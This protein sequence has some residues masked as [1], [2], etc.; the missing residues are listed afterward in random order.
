V[1]CLNNLQALEGCGVG[2]IAVTQGFD[3]DHRN[4]AAKFLLQVLRAAA[5]F[6]RTL[7]VERSRAGQARYRRDYEAGRVGKTVHSRSGKNLPPHRPKKVFDRDQVLR[8]RRQGRSLRAI[9]K[10]MGVGVGTVTW[11]EPLG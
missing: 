6:E 5:E 10:E 7:I 1:D 11:T 3:T 9:A 4:P 8:L 2:F